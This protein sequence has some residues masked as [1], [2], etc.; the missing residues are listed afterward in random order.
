[1]VVFPTDT[2]YG[3][4]ADVFSV[5][6]LERI[7]AIKGRPAALALPVLVA[8]WDQLEMVAQPVPGAGLRLAHRF[9]PGPL[10]LVLPRSPQV[11]DPVT[12][13]G[14]TVA[15]RMPD[16]RVALALAR[17]L[18]RPIIGTSA[19]PSGQADLMTLD[20][21][22]SHLGQ[23]V[24][25]IIRAGPAPGGLASTVVDVTSGVPRL[26]RQGVIPFEEVLEAST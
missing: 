21:V 3:L 5:P 24:D 20:A 14:P 26:V 16:H 19:N 13:G 2:L 8:G 12:G 10:T 4:G 23:A 15:V 18:G 9:W 17:K 22:E 11:P 1:V 25:Y 6:A 7:F